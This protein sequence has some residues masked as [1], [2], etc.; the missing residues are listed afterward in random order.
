MPRFLLAH[1]PGRHRGHAHRDGVPRLDV[2][3]LEQR[4]LRRHRHLPG[5]DE[6]R[7]PGDRHV[8]RES[9]TIAGDAYRIAGRDGER[10]RVG[11]NRRDLL[12]VD[13][14]ARL[15]DEHPG[16]AHRNAGRRVDVRRLERSLLGH[17]H[18]PGDDELRHASDGHVHGAADASSARIANPGSHGAPSTVTDAGA[19]FLGSV[20][21]D[22]LATTAYFQYGLDKRYSQV[23]ASGPN[24]TSQTPAQTVGSDFATHGV[25]P[26]A[27]TGLVPN[28]VYHVRL[29]ATNSAGTTFGAGRDVHDRGGAGARLPD[30]RQDVQHRARVGAGAGRHQRAPRAADRAH[31]DPV[32]RGDRHAPRHARS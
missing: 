22:G 24:Y 27:V 18:L 6:L 32:R 10:N 1:V 26:I 15:R 20:D 11:R 16:N 30:P 14:F 17:R 28:A 2:H 31:P 7:H 8:H 12:P 5:N 13:V 3:R 25:G 21:P 29:V 23:G 19:A 4:P 9:A